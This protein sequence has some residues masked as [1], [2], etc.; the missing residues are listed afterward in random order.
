MPQKVCH[1]NLQKFM[2]GLREAA[3]IQEGCHLSIWAICQISNL[4]KE[5][6]RPIWRPKRQLLNRVWGKEMQPCFKQGALFNKET[7]II[8]LVI[9]QPVHYKHIQRRLVWS[10]HKDDTQIWSI[11]YFSQIFKQ[12]VILQTDPHNSWWQHSTRKV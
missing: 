10:L 7:I 4:D 6:L 11:P 8:S 2:G 12:C 3:R 1:R 9:L 5:N